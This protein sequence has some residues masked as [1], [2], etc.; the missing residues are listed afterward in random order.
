MASDLSTIT[1]FRNGSLTVLRGLLCNSVVSP[2]TKRAYAKAFDEFVAIA[3][4]RPISRAV[5][6]E[7]RASMVGEGLSAATINQRLCAIRKLVHEGR[8]NGLLD[9]VEA[10]RITSVPGVPQQGIRLG[11]WL[12][13][14]EAQH[15]LA[16]PDRTHLIGKRDFAI[17]SVLVYCA[18]RREEFAGIDLRLIQKREDRWVIADLIGK[19][20]RVRT[21]PVPFAAKQAIDDW[22]AAAAITSG[23]VFRRMRKG[24]AITG[25]AVSAWAVWDVVVK[26]AALA[27]IESLSPHD[28]RR[29]CAKL[30]R[31]TGGE[32]EQIQSLLGHEDLSTTAKY[33]NSIQKIRNAVNDRIAL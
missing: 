12:T 11:H 32:L 19:R 24:G 30:C 10:V 14:E 28:L 22:T 25:V 26:A 8:E 17:L 31:E 23:P 4:G 33:L 15:L 6:F 16:V 13:P 20:G 7:Y 5:L 27:G 9:S 1:T 29:T 3:C 2:S 18:L 21:V